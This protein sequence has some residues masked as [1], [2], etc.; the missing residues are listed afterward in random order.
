M[1]N[2]ILFSIC[3][4]IGEQ[5][6]DNEQAYVKMMKSVFI[7]TNFKLRRD[8]IIFMK[9]YFK[10]QDMEALVATDRFQYLYL[11]ELLGYLEDDD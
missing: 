8:G 10:E 6:L 4:N 3:S 1:G 9:D 7:E 5:G 11:P 2:R